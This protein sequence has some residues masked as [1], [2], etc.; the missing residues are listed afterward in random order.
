M[1]KLEFPTNTPVM[2]LGLKTA[3]W[4]TM[5]PPAGV[6]P[7]MSRMALPPRAHQGQLVQSIGERVLR[8]NVI[9]SRPRPPVPP[10]AGLLR[11]STEMLEL[12]GIVVAPVPVKLPLGADWRSWI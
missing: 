8:L 1:T 11:G 2:L 9:F 4:T 7:A 10:L 5:S 12:I 3:N 6:L